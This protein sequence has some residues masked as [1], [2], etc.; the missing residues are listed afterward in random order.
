MPRADS[1]GA[2][3]ARVA[4]GAGLGGTVGPM[5]E[6]HRR[7][8][9]EDANRCCIGR[10]R[11]EVSD[12]SLLGRMQEM[13]SQ[14]GE[15]SENEPSQVEAR[16]GNGQVDFVD[17]AFP[18]EQNIQIDRAWSI[19]TVLV[20]FERRL[21]LPAYGEKAA[22]RDVRLEPDHSVQEPS[23]P[24]ISTAGDRLGFIQRGHSV[25]LGMWEEGEERNCT[26]AIVHTVAHV[27]ADTDKDNFT[28][29]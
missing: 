22:G 6:L 25:D 27:G 26:L 1:G 24:R 21:N 7:L 29:H 5:A 2:S 13:G 14:L 15:G 8:R 9:S 20:T 19:T 23:R 16:V 11:Q 18:I 3:R 17:A 28:G 10:L 12:G 4:P